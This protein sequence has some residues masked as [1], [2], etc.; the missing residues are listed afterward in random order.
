MSA[1]LD[2]RQTTRRETIILLAIVLVALVLRVIYILETRAN[3][4]FDEPVMDPLYHLEWA[5]ALAA[6]EDFQ[7]G[8][9]FRAPLYPWF[10]GTALRFFGESLLWPRL[11]QAGLGALSTWL[12][13]LVGRRA[14]E[15]RA[16]LVAAFFVATNWVLIYFDGELL[17]PTLSIPLNLLALWFSLGLVERPTSRSAGAAGLAWGAAALAR[18]NVLL[19]MPLLFFWVLW[20]ARP[21]WG[22]GLW[23]GLAL[24]GGVMMPILPITFYNLTV[25]GDQ[26]LVSSQAGVNLWIGNNPESDGSTAIVPGTRPQWWDGYHDS[27]ALAERAEG[28]ELRPSEVSAHYSA[29]AWDFLL[30]DPARAL[31]HFAWKFRLFWSDWELGNNADVHFF[32]SRYSSLEAFLPPSFGL[33]APLGLIGFFLCLRRPSRT[34]PLWGFFLAYVASVVLFFVCSRYRAP[35]L[36]ILS[37]FSGQ[38]L[39][40]AWDSLR[41]RRHAALLWAALP[42]LGIAFL[43]QQVPQ[44]VDTTDAKGHWQLGIKALEHDSAAEAVEHFEASIRSNPRFWIARMQLGIAHRRAGDLLAAA[45]SYRAALELKPGDLQTS[46]NLVDLQLQRGEVEEAERVARR[47]IAANPAFPEPYDD[48]ARALAQ[49]ED[50][51]GAR[52]ALL[53]GLERDPKNFMCNYHLGLIEMQRMLPCDAIEPLAR[54]ISSSRAPTEDLHRA[55]QRAWDEAKRLCREE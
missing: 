13:Y 21:R 29:K 18:P 19:F 44:Q 6:G 20:R 15:G 39:V 54:A 4:Y 52:A 45:E 48:L 24:F 27:I 30:E 22:A 17:I 40:V 43:V 47:S 31:R 55:A 32:A 38:A 36:P 5:R 3:P 11:L 25:G 10:L 35:V 46:T 1:P 2:S 16:G 26:V 49:R 34:F 42:L 12:A 28:R 14:F 23:R 50:P 7:A 41:A 9:F 8:P 53:R 33:L 37:I 51:E